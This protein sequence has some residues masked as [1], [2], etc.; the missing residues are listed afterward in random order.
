MLVKYDTNLLNSIT[1][2]IVGLINMEYIFIDIYN[3]S[4]IA[5][6]PAVLCSC[7]LNI[8]I[9]MFENSLPLF[10]DENV[11]KVF[12]SLTPIITRLF[13]LM[14]PFTNYCI[15]LYLKILP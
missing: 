15:I 9:C 10:L 5:A 13:N 12:F 7:T 6:V 1:L 11:I 4:I 2:M 8:T 3:I 14:I